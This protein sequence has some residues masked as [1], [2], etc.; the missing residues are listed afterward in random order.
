LK[1]SY[2]DA[3]AVAVVITVLA[4]ASPVS[5]YA[6]HQ[7]EGEQGT[8]GI[9]STRMGSG[10]AWLPDAAPLAG[11]H[12]S[13]GRWTLMVHGNG[14]LQYD[15]QFGTR[16]DDQ[17]GSVNWLMALAGR[18]AAG[19]T[20][21][22]RAMVSAEPWTLTAR[23]YPQLLQVAEPYGGGI[24][25]DRQHPHDVVSETAVM[26]EHA[27]GTSVAASVYAAPVGEP[28]LGPVTYLHRPSAAYDP[29]TPLGHHAQ[30]VTHTSFGVVTA[31]VFT[32]HLRVEA[33][34][35]NGAHPDEDRTDFDPVRLDSYAARVSWNPGA[36]W[37]AAA[38]V[39]HLAASGGAHVHDALGRFGASVLHTRGSWSTALVYGADLPAG[40][41]H[42]LN[43]LLLETTLELNGVNAV[44]GRAEYVRRTAADLALIGSVSRELDIGAVS[45]GYERRVWRREPLAVGVGARGTLDLVPEELRPFYGSRTPV[46]LVAYLQVRPSARM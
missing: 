28:A 40:A 35:F 16:A 42:P 27:L 8:L 19:G 23:G 7:H 41:G 32:R 1:S 30:D 6:Q 5:S 10:T 33:S 26:Y 20:L 3:A 12:T 21:R 15:R 17:L 4:S 39:G 36:E 25:T 2:T 31:G 46:G 45:V 9:P 34:S 18:P 44:F 14:F 38:W 22:F 11:Y 29:V 37:S 24:V 13:V 43:T